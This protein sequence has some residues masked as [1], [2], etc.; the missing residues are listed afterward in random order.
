MAQIVVRNLDDSVKMKLSQRARKNGHSTEE[1]VRDILRN[2]VGKD[3]GRAPM[4]LGA[5]FKARFNKIG[6]TREI[7]ELRGQQAQPAAL[8]P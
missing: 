4:P 3:G 2:A 7:P 6:L 1:E 5:R 8:V